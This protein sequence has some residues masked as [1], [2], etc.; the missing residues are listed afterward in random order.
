MKLNLILLSIIALPLLF[1]SC[2][3]SKRYD[4]RVHEHHHAAAVSDNPRNFIPKE[5]F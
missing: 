1:V 5:K 2:G 4:V 3:A